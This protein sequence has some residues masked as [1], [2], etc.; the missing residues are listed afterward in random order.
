MAIESDTFG[1]VLFCFLLIVMFGG[2]QSQSNVGT[3]TIIPMANGEVSAS[4]LSV[5]RTPDT[6]VLLSIA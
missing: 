3:V 5:L 6:G 4:R 1:F 2:I